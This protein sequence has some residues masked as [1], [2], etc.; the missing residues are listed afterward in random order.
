[1]VAAAGRLLPALSLCLVSGCKAPPQ[2]AGHASIL[3]TTGAPAH[4]E[5]L[6]RGVKGKACLYFSPFGRMSRLP[7]V[8]LAVDDAIQRVGGAE[9][10]LDATIT[11][12]WAD[13]FL[14]RRTCYRVEGNAARWW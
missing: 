13:W 10:L 2:L 8:G 5:I 3:S 1:M 7:D 6:A 9:V 14:V 12:T 11:Y 4:A